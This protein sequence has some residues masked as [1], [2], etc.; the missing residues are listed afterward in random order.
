MDIKEQQ[1][2]DLVAA[3][4]TSSHAQRMHPSYSYPPT[5][6]DGTWMISAQEAA[7]LA[8]QI[9]FRRSKGNGQRMYR[10]LQDEATNSIFAQAPKSGGA[11]AHDP[12]ACHP[13]VPGCN[14]YMARWSDQYL[15]A[16]KAHMAQIKL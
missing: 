14:F 1:H 13:N 15:V 2:I 12:N 6:S 4:T 5:P 11:F 10:M 16:I 8:C 7:D 3:A 9:A